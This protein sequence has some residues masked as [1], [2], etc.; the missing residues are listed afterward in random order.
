V[1]C[2]STHALY[3]WVKTDYIGRMAKLK[4]LLR[5]FVPGFLLSWYHF[6]WVVLGALIYGF[7]A[8]KMTVVGVTGTDG[9][10]TSVE[11][12]TRIF[13][14]AGFKTCSTSSVWFQINEKKWKNPVKMG[15]PGR[16]FLQRFLRQALREGCT[17][18]VV[19]VS[20]EGILQHRHRFLN[21]HT[22]V[23]TN[24][25]PEHIESHGSFEK[26]RAE[27]QKL[28]QATKGVHVLNANDESVEYFSEFSSREKIFYGVEN[29]TRYLPRRP[30]G[31]QD[32]KYIEA[33][34]IQEHKGGTNFQ[35]NGI[36]FSL[37]LIGQF[38][39]YNALAAICVGM[40]HDISLET[41][42]KALA[43]MERMPGRTDPVITEPFTVLVD[44]AITPKAF[45]NL[46]KGVRRL[47]E[48]RKLICVFGSC[49]GGRDKWRRPIL[50]KIAATYCD[51]IIVTNEDPYDEDPSI[52]I[53]EIIEG[54]GGKGEKILDRRDAIHKALSIAEKGDV[55]VVSGKG[56][57]DAI[58]V[59]GGKKIPWDERKV[60]KEEFA[61]LQRGK[62]GV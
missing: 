12:I 52:I 42:Q 60:I 27:K 31:A 18:A 4:N 13:K 53:E 3:F 41:C 58:A 6:G 22:A 36:D 59:A 14:E 61:A 56:S 48:P 23:V 17:H 10:S 37:R 57:E 34:K 16:F 32:T 50:G 43:D 40:A 44:Y 2:I 51:E 26:Y 54:A 46:Y 28:F 35:V 11:M 15:M 55:I 30:T 21:F 62:E 29:N 49:G 38:N 20:S 45:E 9:K 24:L 8:K 7:P 47:F 5:K 33:S 1:G 25:S 39:A 19:E